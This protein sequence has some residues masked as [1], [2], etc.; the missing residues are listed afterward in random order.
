[1]RH[2]FVTVI[3][4]LLI[5]MIRLQHNLHA[6]YGMLIKL[7][8]VVFIKMMKDSL[9]NLEDFNVLVMHYVC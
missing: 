6:C 9:I 5:L 4:K 7:S 2:L 3:L 8:L 1:M